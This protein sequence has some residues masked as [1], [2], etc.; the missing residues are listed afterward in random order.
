MTPKYDAII[1]FPNTGP[2]IKFSIEISSV[3]V[4]ES[5]VSVVY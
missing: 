5:A 2:E 3:N 1:V 4:T